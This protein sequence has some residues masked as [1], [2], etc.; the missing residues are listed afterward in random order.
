MKILEDLFSE[1]KNSDRVRIAAGEMLM[2][3]DPEKNL[4]NFIMELDE[5][6][7][8]NQNNLYN[9]LLKIIAGTKCGGM[10]DI[11]RRLLKNP[12]MVEKVSA[13]TMAANNNLISLADDIKALTEDRN[14]SLARRARQTLKKLGI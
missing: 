11:T 8:K 5:A 14:E 1:R 6:K 9:G 7:Q 10:E 2:Q 13:L 12:G 4:N 3:N